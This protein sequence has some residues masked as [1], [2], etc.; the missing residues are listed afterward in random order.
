MKMIQEHKNPSIT[1][2]IATGLKLAK[3]LG[4]L[5]VISLLMNVLDKYQSLGYACLAL[6][7][8]CS[9]LSLSPPLLKLAVPSLAPGAKAVHTMIEQVRDTRQS[10]PRLWK[11]HPRCS[12]TFFMSGVS[13]IKSIYEAPPWNF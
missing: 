2:S 12:C 10:I 11:N 1:Q 3:G 9:F 6:G 8:L 13:L 4:L 5:Y 7:G